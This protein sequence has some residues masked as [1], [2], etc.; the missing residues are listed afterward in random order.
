MECKSKVTA[1]KY[2]QNIIRLLSDV[3]NHYERCSGQSWE[4]CS[5]DHRA[6]C[7]LHEQLHR[8]FSRVDKPGNCYICTGNGTIRNIVFHKQRENYYKTC[9]FSFLPFLF[10]RLSHSNRIRMKIQSL[11]NYVALITYR[12]QNKLLLNF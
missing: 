6:N 9:A 11:H 2:H 3:C 1:I 10:N 8:P 7:F 12:K 4:L 5:L